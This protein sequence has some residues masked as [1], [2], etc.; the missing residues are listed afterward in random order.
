MTFLFSA[1]DNLARWWHV[2]LRS[3]LFAATSELLLG[4]LVQNFRR[5]AL[6]HIILLAYA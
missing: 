5:E 2:H 3:S 4:S 1:L 6:S